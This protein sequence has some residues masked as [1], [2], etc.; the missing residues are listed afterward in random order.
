M[1]MPHRALFA[2]FYGAAAAF[3]LATDIRREAQEV[4]ASKMPGAA[5]EGTDFLSAAYESHIVHPVAGL[6]CRFNDIYNHVMT[7][8]I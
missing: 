3:L 4:L 7:K 1:W 6:W 5:Q 2:T 8:Y